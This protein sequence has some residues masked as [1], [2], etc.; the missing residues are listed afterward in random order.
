MGGILR[1]PLKFKGLPLK[2]QTTLVADDRPGR[3]QRETW[4]RHS[5]PSQHAHGRK[6]EKVGEK[7]GEKDA[8]VYDELEGVG[9]GLVCGF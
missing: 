5:A 1:L 4:A 8:G 2:P 3:H 7:A 9:C 6:R